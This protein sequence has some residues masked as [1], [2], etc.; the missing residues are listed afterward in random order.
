M[1]EYEQLLSHSSTV[2]FGTRNVTLDYKLF[3]GV[4]EQIEGKG[5]LVLKRIKEFHREYEWV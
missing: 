1:E 4:W 2:A 3:P 5:R